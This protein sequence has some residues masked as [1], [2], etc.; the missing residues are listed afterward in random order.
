MAPNSTPFE[1]RHNIIA[2]DRIIFMSPHRNPQDYCSAFTRHDEI[3]ILP[4]CTPLRTHRLIWQYAGLGAPL[5]DCP[6]TYGLLQ[7][8]K[9]F[10]PSWGS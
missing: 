2:E 9:V 4:V 5:H 7:N 10:M 8:P 6:E 1:L 3:G